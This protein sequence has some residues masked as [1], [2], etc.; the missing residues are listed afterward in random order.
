M[1]ISRFSQSTLAKSKRSQQTTD[2]LAGLIPLPYT[3]TIGTATDGGTGTTVSVAFT[4]NATVPPGTFYTALSSPGSITASGSSSPITVSGLTSGTAYTFQVR[5]SNATGNSAYS[6]ASN[7]VTPVDPASFVSIATA[8]GTGSSGTITFSSIPSTYKHLQLRWIARGSAGAGNWATGA[9]IRFNGDS[10]ATNYYNH[11]LEGNGSTAS[12]GA[13]NSN[14]NW[15]KTT[16]GGTAANIYAVGIMDILDYASTNKNKVMRELNG[17]DLNGSGSMFLISG[18][19]TNTAAINSI[20][21]VSDA[22]YGGNWT[23]A[24]QFALYGIKG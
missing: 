6:A 15:F 5:A 10:T 20:S 2:A 17:A 4:P 18:G 9:A 22:T 1:T 11:Y 19:W 21:I 16:S 3:P 23:T 14:N 12:S 8:S 7:S 24:T 13:Q